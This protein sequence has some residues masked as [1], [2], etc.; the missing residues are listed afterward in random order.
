MPKKLVT[1][2]G[3]EMTS[4]EDMQFSKWVNN[5]GIAMNTLYPHQRTEIA[6]T[7]LE[8]HRLM[9]PTHLKPKQ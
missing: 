4:Y 8:N 6:R 1:S 9:E 7:W 5:K 2:Y 3:I